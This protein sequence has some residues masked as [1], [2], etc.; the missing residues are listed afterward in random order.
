MSN[1]KSD[2]FRKPIA[3]VGMGCRFPGGS[4]GPKKFWD[5]LLNKV[6]GIVDVPKDRWN[7][8]KFYDED[9][10]KPGK[11]YVK[12]GG[13]LQEKI[14]EF[15]PMFFGMSPREAEVV[16]PQQKLLLEVAW[17][18]ME[19]A[20]FTKEQIYG[21]KTG[22]FIGA[23]DLD[24]KLIQ[25]SSDNLDNVNSF[26]ATSSTMTI[27]SNRI[28]YVFDFSGPAITMDTACSSSVV[29]THVAVQ[30]LR[31]GDCDVA[32]VGGVNTMLVPNYPI[33]MCKGHFL[34]DHG[35]SK[36][37]D[38]DGNGYARAEGAGIIVLKPLE[39][40]LKDGDR[41]YSVIVDTGLNQDGHTAGISLPNPLAQEKLIKS[42]YEKAGIDPKDMD[43]IE[44][45]GTGTEAGDPK[46][47]SAIGN[48]LKSAGRSID[49]RCL[50]GSV[51]SNIGH[52]EAAAGVAGIMKA[53]LVMYYGIVP[54][55][56]FFDN[57]NP[58][59]D[60]ETTPVKIPV[61]PTPLKKDKKVYYAG[62]NSFGYGG[63]NGHIL[64][65]SPP[66]QEENVVDEE[67][68]DNKMWVVPVSGKSEGAVKD[69]AK[70][71]L[72]FLNENNDVDLK[73]VV[74]TLSK[75]RVHHSYRMTTVV[76]NKDELKESLK[77][78]NEG[79]FLPGMIFNQASDKKK[80]LVFVLTGMGPQ[81]WKMGQELYATEPVFRKEVERCD[82]IFKDHAGWSIKEE[83]LKSESESKMSRTEIAQPAN[84]VIQVALTRLLE[85]KGIVPDAVV[86]HSVGEVSASYISGA[87]SL[88][89]GLLVSYHR[90]RLQ[91]TCANQGGGMLAVGMSEHN[92][93]P[94][95]SKY[96]D[97]SIAAINSS[98][99]VTLS[100]AESSLKEIA[101]N[102][103]KN[104]VFN[105][106]L[107]VEVAYH[108][109]QMN[110]IHDELIEKLSV[111]MPRETKVPLYSTVKGELVNG[112]E[113]D[114]NYWWNNARGSVHFADAIFSI[115]EDLGDS[116]F[117]E[118]GPHPVLRNSIKEC[119]KEKGFDANTMQTLNLKTSERLTFYESLGRIYTLRDDTL[120]WD[121]M[122]SKNGKMIQMPTYAWQLDKYWHESDVSREKRLGREGYIYFNEY[123]RTPNPSWQVEVNKY[124]IPFLPDHKVSNMTIFPG[125][126]YVDV[127]LSMHDELFGEKQ[128]TLKDVEF[129]N[130]LAVQPKALPM[131]MSSFDSKT[132]NF[133]IHSK[134][135]LDINGEWKLNAKG[136]ILENIICSTEK[137]VDLSEFTKQC[138]T[139]IDVEEFY[140][141]LDNQGLNYGPY[142]RPIKQVSIGK[143]RVLVKI[144]A[145]ERIENNKGEY[146]LHP[147][148]L[149]ATFQSFVA[150]VVSDETSA[151][152]PYV[153]VKI[154][155]MDLFEAPERFCWSFAKITKRTDSAL[156]GDITIFN[157]DGKVLANVYGLKCQVI[158]NADTETSSVENNFYEMEWVEQQRDTNFD[159][160]K[161]TLLLNSNT[162]LGKQVKEEFEKRNISVIGIKYADSFAKIS[163][164][165]FSVRFANK[166]DMLSLFESL[167]SQKINLITDLS[168][169]KYDF[170]GDVDVEKVTDNCM[171]LTNIVQAL[172]QNDISDELKIVTV[173]RGAQPIDNEDKEI[174]LNKTAMLGLGQL[175]ENEHPQ[176][177]C[178]MLDLDFEETNDDAKTIV[179]EALA[180]THFADI[181]IRKNSRKVRQLIPIKTR[182]IEESTEEVSVEEAIEITLSKPGSFENFI[183]KTTERKQPKEDE[184]EVRI[185]ASSLNFKDLLKVFGRIDP[186][187]LENT[188]FGNG[189]GMEVSGIITAIG[190]NVKNW[191]VGDEVVTPVQG[192]S[193]RTYATV[194]EFFVIPKPKTLSFFEATNFIGYLTAYRALVDVARLEKGEKVLIH[195]ATG[196]V[197]IPAVQIAQHIGAEIFATAGTEKK[198]EY[199]R[200]LGIKHVMD[201]RS[202]SF[203]DDIKE[204]TNQGVDVVI[205]AIGGE[206]LIQ[207][208]ELLAPYGRFVEIGKKDITNN[209]ALPMQAFNKNLTFAAIDIDRMFKDKASRIKEMLLDTVEKFENKIYQPNPTTTFN[210][211]QVGESFKFMSRSEHLGKIVIDFTKGTLPVQRTT[212][213]SWFNSSN[214]YLI[215]GGTRGLGLA[216]AQWLSK[217]GAESLVL[218]SRSGAKSEEAK[219][220]VS[221]MEKRGTKVIVKA[222]DVTN[223]EKIQEVI[224]EVDTV[225]NPLKGIFHG[226]MVLDDGF[227]VNLEKENFMKVMGP[228]VAGAW[229]LH[230][231]TLAKNCELDFFLNF[232]SISS[233]VGNNG[234]ANYVAANN[235]LDSFS[236][237]RN[238]KGLVATT[239][240]WGALGETG[241]VSRDQNVA[242]IL[243][244]SGIKGLSTKIVLESLDKILSDKYKQ[245]GVF[246][247]DWSLW[248][249]NNK[250]AANSSRFETVVENA[251][252]SSTSGGNEKLNALL[253]ELIELE[254]SERQTKMEDLIK[255]Q[256]AKVLKFSPEKIDVKQSIS[257]LGIDSLMTLELSSNIQAELGLSITSMELLNGP[258]VSEL[259]EQQLEKIM[260]E[261][262]DMMSEIDDMSEEELNKLLEESEK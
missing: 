177:S 223:E 221:E 162:D 35:H 136:H 106:F 77:T 224:N 79:G 89:D 56:I 219:Q 120:N 169:A 31:N 124:L 174:D 239:I 237:Y 61:E 260:T 222:V 140:E 259:A 198:R 141:G 103:E 97:V 133:T 238:S 104:S 110:P 236:Y 92:I 78:F 112:K 60:F 181:A 230:K 139:T 200:N 15:D 8:N 194:P 13:F 18:A 190:K 241:V 261:I 16:D 180:Q 134:D 28:S 187:A 186:T 249:S 20:G 118:I 131:M 154:E 98:T 153:P 248:L 130:V 149:D 117:L 256:I 66:K 46:E 69:L 101:E 128:C 150:A 146:L 114:A 257:N 85:S 86:G 156:W 251:S 148:I 201:S 161:T 38:A 58:K 76:K 158:K 30:N 95:I 51:K 87:L 197:G 165:E 258:S 172:Q 123:L 255:L 218:L 94:L 145:D 84:F 206:A 152:D 122:N 235:F 22:V 41:I 34:S 42:V 226:A 47:L 234:Q 227:L 119:A 178:S 204:K 14:D 62:V 253:E 244:S 151:T 17:E 40:A 96:D 6:D 144:E 155:R 214:T 159:S 52:L 82:V 115:F 55:D 19:D 143:D 196:G 211:S 48:V 88:E 126:G 10:D 233:I 23:F 65:S 64:L 24:N 67:S 3:I 50:V 12:N 25:L 71:Y 195:N 203:V 4:Y 216:I 243:E 217:K 191:K 176:I 90:S 132:L 142:F 11:M 208:F 93:L 170:N 160:I 91:Q 240:N 99:T 2:S 54:A 68:L 193:F 164:D 207:S 9:K 59:I 109:P 183:Y 171:I 45:H 127:A 167:K 175:I 245:V 33:A 228:K 29:A 229:N 179:L 108:S 173:T 7:I 26:T 129:L 21:S 53:A 205:N 166:E 182:E 199:L 107:K 102:L 157:R 49:D 189:I 113:I 250:K 111:L 80:K 44:A 212:V 121:S 163:D 246:D 215:T 231:A 70:K 202:L 36:A 188:Y 37:F 75:K 168:V 43:Y 242:S 252:V 192:G 57:P 247:V 137:S 254:E 27:I 225:E 135:R 147:T 210:A 83:M 220:A 100:G 105:R 116:D 74:F 213:K 32:L 125:A 184:V 81:H 185:Y 73:D 138:P 72:N 262:D 1:N 209:S 232:S 63:T 39:N 5:N